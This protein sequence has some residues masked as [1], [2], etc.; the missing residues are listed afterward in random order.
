MKR[1]IGIVLL[2][3]ITMGVVTACAPVVEVLETQP[4][5]TTEEKPVR[6][7]DDYYRYING[8]ALKNAVFEKGKSS[9]ADS[10]DIEIVED[11]V[12]SVINDSIA[13]SG[14]EKGSEEYVIKTV[15]NA[16]IDYDFNN[17]PIP[18]DLVNIIDEIE[19]CKTVDE[20]MKIDA[21]LVR[22]YG[23]ESILGLTIDSNYFA[24]EERILSFPQLS[25]V[26]RLSFKEMRE[27]QFAVD[28]VAEDAELILRTR[29]YDKEK[30]KE[31]AIRLA[32]I[33]IELYGS[34]DMDIIDSIWQYE[35]TKIYSADEINNIFTNVNISEY[36]KIIGFDQKYCKQFCVTDADQLKCLN[37]VM[38]D[39]NIEALKTL[40]LGNV[41]IK[42]MRFIAPHYKELA[43]GVIDS[44][45][46]IEDQAVNEIMQN[47]SQETDPLYVERYYTKEMDDALVAMCDEIREGY[48]GLIT[49]ASWLTE[50]TRKG[51]L[52]KLDNIVY[53]TGSD[54]K[55]HDNSRFENLSG[56]YYQ[57][58]LQYNQIMRHDQIA[59][60]SEPVDRESVDM[61][62]QM[63]N[64]CYDPLSNSILITVAITNAPFFDVN[65]DHYTNLGGLGGVIAHEMGH[66]FDSNCIVFDQDGIYNPGWIADEDMNVLIERNEK[67]ASYFEDNFVVFG[68]YR[69]DGEQTLG[70]NYADLGAMECIT[71][72][73]KTDEDL[74]KIFAAW[75]TVWCVKTIDSVIIEQIAYDEH[76]PNIL[77]TN[78]ILSTVDCFYEL[79]D[80]KEGDGMYIAPENR[81]SRWY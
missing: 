18:E 77:R 35:Y 31:Y 22:D 30:A 78:A 12:K 29:G 34:T 52:K 68:V 70:E 15:Y 38:T 25:G 75:A 66:A 5:E 40:E 79:Y 23:L 76:S 58:M 45:D 20:L 42:Y 61:P 16:F 54:L 73:A 8:E 80:V 17:E 2:G 4:T 55:R 11:Q 50:G 32:N 26:L 14:Y 6:P 51:L 62:M 48:R 39:D 10:F 56:N 37:S 28:D 53:I 7:Q 44:Y 1:L 33:A 49:N 46:P 63:I 74:E 59:S 19:K 13:G 57:I 64:A 24:D 71:S 81:I 27:S 72:L 3:A 36:L 60:L 21:K 65:A 43:E 41:Y 67:A 47:F 69:V 9:A